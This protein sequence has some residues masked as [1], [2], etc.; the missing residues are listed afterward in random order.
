MYYQLDHQDSLGNSIIFS[1]SFY[2]ETTFL[3]DFE[4]STINNFNADYFDGSLYSYGPSIPYYDINYNENCCYYPSFSNVDGIYEETC[5][6]DGNILDC[7]GMWR[8]FMD[9]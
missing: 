7:A 6:C 3:F 1:G 2:D 9:K 5:D 8:Q 4:E